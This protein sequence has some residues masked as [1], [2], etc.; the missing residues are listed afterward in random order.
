MNATYEALNTTATYYTNGTSQLNATAT[1]QMNATDEVLNNTDSTVEVEESKPLSVTYQYQRRHGPLDDGEMKDLAAH[2]GDWKFLESEI[3][4]A[5]EWPTND[6]CAEFPNRDI[7]WDKLPEKA[8]QRDGYY[9][10]PFLGEGKALVMR[11]MEAIL[12]EYGFGPTP[13]T[14]DFVTRR[15][16]SPFALAFFNPDD[17]AERRKLSSAERLHQAGKTTQ[18]SYSGLVRRLLHAVFTRNT[19]NL[20]MGGHSA[21]AGHG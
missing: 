12:A 21:A 16:Q 10:K 14:K 13:E 6:Y 20:V 19:F 18:K 15:D 2:Y 1:N 4:N 3:M 5:G 11:A 8:W 7:P 9:V 17:P